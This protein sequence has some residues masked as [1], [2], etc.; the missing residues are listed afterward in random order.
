MIPKMHNEEA[1]TLKFSKSVECLNS[2]KN[3][4]HRESKQRLLNI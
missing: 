2:E 1:R 3:Y 4:N